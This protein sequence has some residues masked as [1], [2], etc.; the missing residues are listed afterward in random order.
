MFTNYQNLG[1]LP[2]G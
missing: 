1:H 2:T